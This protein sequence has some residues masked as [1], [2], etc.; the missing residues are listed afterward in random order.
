MKIVYYDL[1]L[2]VLL[3]D[4]DDPETDNCEIWVDCHDVRLIDNTLHF[5]VNVDWLVEPII[6]Y[7]LDLAEYSEYFRNKNIV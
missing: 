7:N 5:Y 6:C 3:F 2:E 4:K 1:P